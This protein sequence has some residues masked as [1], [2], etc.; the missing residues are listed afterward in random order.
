MCYLACLLGILFSLRAAFRFH[1][2]ADRDKSFCVVHHCVGL[3]CRSETARDADKNALPETAYIY[4]IGETLHPK[5]CC[6]SR[7]IP[8]RSLSPAL[9]SSPHLCCWTTLTL[10]QTRIQ[11]LGNVC[12]V[13]GSRTIFSSFL[14]RETVSSGRRG[15]SSSKQAPSSA[16]RTGSILKLNRLGPLIW[17]GSALSR[18]LVPGCRGDGS[19][20]PFSRHLWVLIVCHR[21]RPSGSQN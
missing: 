19:G 8:L 14:S 4:H 5:T 9:F 13:G 20:A 12:K 21:S 17:P 2:P 16:C 18:L 15:P 3:R 10:W 11:G 6:C 7:L 1:R